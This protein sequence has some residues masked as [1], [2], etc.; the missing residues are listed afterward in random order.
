[1][2]EEDTLPHLECLIAT[3]RMHR[4]E[5]YVEYLKLRAAESQ[6]SEACARNRAAREALGDHLRT[7]NLRMLK[8][9]GIPDY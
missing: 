3:V 4:Y 7:L 9:V 2:P 5:L 1:M 8:L 6:D